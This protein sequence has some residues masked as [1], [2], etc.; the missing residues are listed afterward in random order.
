MP[1][2]E[3]VVVAVCNR[4]VGVLP[5]GVRLE[6]VLLQETPSNFVEYTGD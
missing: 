4:L 3:N 6:R 5:A 2:T 1:S